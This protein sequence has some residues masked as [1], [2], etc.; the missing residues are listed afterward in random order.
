MPLPGPD[1]L[2]R[3][4]GEPQL[5]RLILGCLT[6][7]WE[8]GSLSRISDSYPDNY[9][10]SESTNLAINWLIWQMSQP[11]A[12]VVNSV[13]GRITAPSPLPWGGGWGGGGGSAGTQVQ[14]SPQVSLHLKAHSKLRHQSIWPS[15]CATKAGRISGL[16]ACY[17]HRRERQPWRRSG[18]GEG[19][20]E[21]I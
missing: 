16:R 13:Q 2:G 7:E 18:G 9:H 6:L 12:R 14:M 3:R 11:T 20:K 21:G 10:L 8:S 17:R 19:N 5:S 4:E 1:P 15:F